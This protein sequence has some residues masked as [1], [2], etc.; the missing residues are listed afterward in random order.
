MDKAEISV[1]PDFSPRGL[2]FAITLSIGLHL[3]IV[4][5]L[6]HW[7]QAGWDSLSSPSPGR[8]I[9][10]TVAAQG[11]QET[12]SQQTFSPEPASENNPAIKPPPIKQSTDKL[13]ADTAPHD[14]E[15]SKPSITGSFKERTV[16]AA[17]IKQSA[18][19]IASDIA[20]D[21]KQEVNEKPDSVSAILERAL[22]KPREKPGIYSQ[23]NGITRIVTKQGHTYC[24]KALDDWRIIDPE[25][26][27]R[28]SMSCH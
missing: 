10:I 13:E 9:R 26:D 23:A 8:P 14:S 22:N 27:M 2:T 28:V 19:T 3:L 5:H 21:E 7:Y 25:D 6:G 16:S 24:I 1:Q 18:A 17:Q 15:P 4:W 20:K 11:S 12:E